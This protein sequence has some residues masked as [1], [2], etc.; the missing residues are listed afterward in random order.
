MTD[1]MPLLI[2]AGGTPQGSNARGAPAG[3]TLVGVKGALPLPS[4]RPLVAEVAHRYVAS[5]R[6]QRPILIGPRDAYAALTKEYEVI[7]VTGSLARSLTCAAAVMRDRFGLHGPIAISTC[8]ILPR[9]EEIASLL[10]RYYDPVS[11]CAFWGQLVEEDPARLGS[12]AWKPGYEF[13]DEQGR[14]RHLYPGHLVIA[15]PHTLR[16]E[17]AAQLLHLAYGYRNQPLPKRVIGMTVRSLGMLLG[18]DLHRLLRLRLPKLTCAIP[19]HCLRAYRAYRQRILTVAGFER[20]FT[21]TFVDD[22]YQTDRATV[23][24]VTDIVSFARDLDTR[25][26]FDEATRGL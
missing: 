15:R 3:D 7:H 11:D 21:A 4:G 22:A 25:A 8:D 20:A 1:A 14:T 12:S 17:V 19:F 10:Q 23:F 18:Q 5:G 6:F 16:L 2:L 26:E 9:A 13:L 24:A